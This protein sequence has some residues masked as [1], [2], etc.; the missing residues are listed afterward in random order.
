MITSDCNCTLRI[1]RS[2]NTGFGIPALQKNPAN[3]NQQDSYI[4][5]LNIRG[6]TDLVHRPGNKTNIRH[7][8]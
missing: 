7:C 5:L 1:I 2:G 3:H 8:Q 6:I 4:H